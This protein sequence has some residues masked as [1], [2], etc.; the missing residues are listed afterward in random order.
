MMKNEYILLNE[1]FIRTPILSADSFFEELMDASKLEGLKNMLN[2]S[3]VK[4]A[5][6]IAN[7]EFYYELTKEGAASG[8]N[9]KKD[10]RQMETLYNYLNRMCLRQ[11]P[12]GMMSY[13]QMGEFKSLNNNL[14]DSKNTIHANADSEWTISLQRQLEQTLDIFT[15]LEVVSNRFHI[16]NGNRIYYPYITAFGV[17]DSDEKIRKGEETFSIKYNELLENILYWTSSYIPIPTLI[18]KIINKYEEVTYEQGIEY[19]NQLVKCEV[20]FTNLRPHLLRKNHLNKIYRVLDN[21]NPEHDKTKYME[22]LIAEIESLHNYEKKGLELISHID[23]INNKMESSHKSK[24]YLQIDMVGNNMSL[25]ADIKKS[26]EEIAD[27]IMCF[28]SVDYKAIEIQQIKNYIINKC[29]VGCEIPLIDLI[30]SEEYVDN[31]NQT[32]ENINIMDNKNFKLLSKWCNEMSNEDELNITDDMLSFLKYNNESVNYD[33]ISDIEVPLTLI[34]TKSGENIYN[35]K[36]K[37]ISSGLGGYIGR[38]AYMLE[39]D[40]IFNKYRENIKNITDYRIANNNII[41][42]ELSCLGYSNRIMNVMSSSVLE[43]YEIPIGSE[44]SLKEDRTIN[45]NDIVCGVHNNKVYIKWTNN[46]KNIIPKKYNM[47]NPDSVF[48]QVYKIL[49]LIQYEYEKPVYC[50]LGDLLKGREYLPRIRYKNYILSKRHW[51]LSFDILEIY[52][53]ET[54]REFYR[55]MNLWRLKYRVPEY[56]GLCEGDRTI[57]Y[58]LNNYFHKTILYRKIQKGQEIILTELDYDLKNNLEYNNFIREYIFT[59]YNNSLSY[60]GLNFVN[61]SRENKIRYFPNNKW[62]YYK[63]YFREDRQDEF[64]SIYLKE[65]FTQLIN[66]EGIENIFYI[67]YKDNKSHLRLRILAD[68]KK[69]YIVNYVTSKL[70]KIDNHIKLNEVTIDTYKP[71]IIRYGGECV[72][73]EIINYFT[74]DSKNIIRLIEAK[75]NSKLDRMYLIIFYLFE[76]VLRIPIKEVDKQPFLYKFADLEILK[77]RKNDRKNLLDEFI[78]YKREMSRYNQVVGFNFKYIDKLNESLI[79]NKEHLTNNIE[80]IYSSLI[81]MSINRFKVI[82]E[83]EETRILSILYQSYKDVNN[84]LKYYESRKK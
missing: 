15:G 60:K 20:L 81:H 28:C 37:S 19:I 45:L 36:T 58:N 30:Y 33:N 82:D 26:I 5:L 74:H 3:M 79:K 53:Q 75:N 57:Y 25:S 43:N 23:Q 8:E 56:I 68:N 18:D 1:Y 72:F 41:L 84:Y 67:R 14:T 73:D 44:S 65:V 59:F 54:E 40:I 52:G 64:I 11:S 39:E 4:E 17:K 70:N 38:F 61:N 80:S 7:K 34:K 76:I 2:N 6:F 55:K 31:I 50:Y 24:E 22:G 51:K 9:L 77:S 12:Y 13:I 21:I 35:I 46:N 66:C 63:I 32:H 83:E 62:L 42:A 16:I 78:L 69:N 71:E 27:F 49:S 47:I 29:D 10:K 48:P